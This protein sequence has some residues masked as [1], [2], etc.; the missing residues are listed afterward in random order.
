MIYSCNG[1]H[2]IFISKLQNI[3]NSPCKI[4]CRYLKASFWWLLW[5]ECNNELKRWGRFSKWEKVVFSSIF[6]SANI[7]SV[8]FP[9]SAWILYVTGYFLDFNLLHVAGLLIVSKQRPDSRRVIRFTGLITISSGLKPKKRKIADKN[10][11]FRDKTNY[12]I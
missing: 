4:T 6:P 1:Y 10:G 7:V 3:S 5:I 12:I 2:R 9:S 11:Q 8:R